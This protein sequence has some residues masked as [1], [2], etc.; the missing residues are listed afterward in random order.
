MQRR[1]WVT[2]QNEPQGR[3]VIYEKNHCQEKHTA[4]N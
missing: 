3:E 2:M 4:G 1:G